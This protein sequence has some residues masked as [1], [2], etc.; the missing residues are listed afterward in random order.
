MRLAPITQSKK[1]VRQAYMQTHRL[2]NPYA[3]P[4]QNY[5]ESNY[6]QISHLEDL[7]YKLF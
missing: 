7:D 1:T 2:A 6:F 4:K 5:F 3:V